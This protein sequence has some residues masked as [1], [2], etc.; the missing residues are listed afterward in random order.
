VVDPLVRVVRE[1]ADFRTR[2]FTALILHELGDRAVRQLKRELNESTVDEEYRR[3]L[4]ILDTFPEDFEEQLLAALCHSSS[5]IRAEAGKLLRRIQGDIH[6]ILLDVLKTADGSAASEAI[7]QLGRLKISEAVEPILQKIDGDEVSDPVLY[8]GCMA[9]G[10]IGDPR[11]V[12]FLKRVLGE[13]R[14]RFLRRRHASKVRLAAAWALAQIASPEAIEA[15]RKVRRDRDSD[16]RA[17]A[18]R[19]VKS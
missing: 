19:T 18:A 10:R 11:C 8:E 13:G 16:I 12:S 4:G 9:L 17:L 7:L 6:R 3:I 2:K 14:I 15:L 5:A 1:S